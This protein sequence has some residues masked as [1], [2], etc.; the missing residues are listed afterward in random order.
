MEVCGTH[1]VAIFRHG[2][3]HLLPPNVNLLSG[4]G[5]PV[6]VTPNI[7]IDKAIALAGEP[8]VVLATYGDM[9][10]VPGSYKSLEQAKAAGR[11]V[12]VVYSALDALSL[13]INN[14]ERSVIFFAIGFETTAPGVACTILEAER[15]GVENF[16]A[17]V[18]H[19]LIPPAMEALVEGGEVRIDGF[20]CPG[21]VSTVIGSLPYEFIPQKYG[22]PCVISGFEPLDIL[23]SIDMLLE[24]R[25]EGKA[26]VEIQYRRA[27][28]PE[29]NR[30]AQ[31][32]MYQVFKVGSAVWRGLGEIPESGLKLHHRYQR[33]DAEKFFEV[34]ME[35]SRE[36]KGC[37]CGE[38]LRGL[39][40]PPQCPLFAKACTPEHP[41][42]PCM[43]S[44]EGSCAAWYHYGAPA[45]MEVKGNG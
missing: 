25:E 38:I 3:R 17:F 39:N 37:K 34:T 43:V 35:P 44:S 18:A 22:I 23:Q 11:D 19:K 14:P 27:V 4:P 36:H 41:V 33:F 32:Y 45:L 12:R 8:R 15:A 10:K 28:R 13:A 16:F 20:I 30:L 26:K 40:T 9:F 1:T 29:G 31:G 24:Q 5:C 2:I 21:H 7:E 42:G 6:C